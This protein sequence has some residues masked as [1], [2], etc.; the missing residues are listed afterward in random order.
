M[1]KSLLVTKDDDPLIQ[2]VLD[3]MTAAGKIAI[4]DRGA[5]QYTL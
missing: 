3:D 2:R 4:G 1:I 5:V